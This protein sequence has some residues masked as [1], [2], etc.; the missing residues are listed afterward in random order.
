[1]K[2]DG[3][4]FRKIGAILGRSGSSMSREYKRNNHSQELGYLPDTAVILAKA[5]KAHHGTKIS[6]HP[7]LGSLILANLRDGRYSPEMIAGSLKVKGATLSIS[8]ETIYQYIYSTQGKQLKLYQYLMRARPKRN[9]FYG[10]KTRSNYGIPDR[11]SISQRPEISKEEFGHFEADLTFTKNSKKINL[12]TMV[13][14]K[15]GY[16]MA[17]LNYSKASENITMN[18]LHHLIRYPKG[19]R[20]TITFDNG[21]EFIM[22]NK[23]EACYWHRYLFLSSW[24]SMGKTICGKYSCYITSIYSKEN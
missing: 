7:E 12:L 5:R 10:R 22:H 19:S 4:S 1:M 9:E 13:E 6:R 24:I 15:T 3:L 8:T 21:K 18:M 14:R 11:V 16:L 17:D 20:K 23:L 2:K